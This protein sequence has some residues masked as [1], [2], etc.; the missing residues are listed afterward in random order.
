MSE[1]CEARPGRSSSGIAEARD[2]TVYYFT[3]WG[4][5]ILFAG[6]HP[7]NSHDKHVVWCT[8]GRR[9]QT[10]ACVGACEGAQKIAQ[11]DVDHQQHRVHASIVVRMAVDAPFPR[12]AS[13]GF[14]ASSSLFRF[15]GKA[16]TR[17]CRFGACAVGVRPGNTFQS[18][19]VDTG[20][21]VHRVWSADCKDRQSG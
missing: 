13:T 9:H 15:L 11:R 16:L 5:R 4:T 17:V 18:L 10:E 1:S 14:T 3:F 21:R 2:W 6:C 8:N 12:K 20:V 7:K 19:H